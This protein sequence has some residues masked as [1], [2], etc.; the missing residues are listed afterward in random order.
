MKNHILSRRMSCVMILLG[1]L[2]PLSLVLPL[3]LEYAARA[4]SA[5]E[6][7]ALSPETV[8][9][10]HLSSTASALFQIT[11]H[12]HINEVMPK[13]EE[14]AFEWVE[15]RNPRVFQ[16]YL[17]LILRNASGNNGSMLLPRSPASLSAPLGGPV[18]ISGWQITDEDG[19]NYTI[20]DALP[21]V[22]R[23][24]Y[25]LILFDGLGPANDDYDLSDGVAV[26]HSPPGVA[27]I[28]EDVADQVA[29]Y[30][31]STHSPDTIQDFVAYGAPAGDQAANAVAADLWQESWQVNIYIGAG[32]VVESEET[33]AGQS[34]GL[35]PEQENHSP[36][37]WALY[38][39]DDVT[40]GAPNPMPQVYWSAVDDGAVMG[41]DGFALGWSWVPN[42]T[43]QLQVDDDPAFD[44]PW[45][46]QILDDPSYAPEGPVPAGNYWWQVR[47]IDRRGVAGAWSLPAQVSVVAVGASGGPQ[48]TGQAHA[49]MQQHILPI[50]WLRQRKDTR[51]LCLDGC[52][53]GDPGDDSPEEAWDSVHPNRIYEHGRQNCALASIAMIVTNYGGDLSQDRLGYRLFE[54][55][56]AP[57]QNEGGLGEPRVDLGHDRFASGCGFVGGATRDL[58]AWALGVDNSDIHYA[59]LKPSFDT[60]RSWLDQGRPILRATSGHATVIGGYRILDDGTEQVRLLN[61]WSGTTWE[62]YNSLG[63]LCHYAAPV[64]APNVRSDE[65]SIST[66]EDGDGIMDW[67]E[68]YRFPTDHTKGDT[69]ADGQ[70]DKVDISEYLFDLAGGYH[71]R[72]PDRDGDGL[73]KEVDPDNDNGGSKDGCED[74]NHNGRYEPALGETSNFKPT[75]EKQCV[76]PVGE[77]VYIPAGEFQMGCDETN[78]NEDCGDYELPLHTVYLD[79]YYIDRY[80][81]TNAQYAQCV[82]AGFCTLPLHSYSYARPSYYNNPVYAYYPVIYISWHDA[83]DYCTWLGKRLPT[84]AEWEKAARGSSDTRM[85]PWGDEALDCSRLN[86]RYWNGSNYV[87]C[88]GDTSQV[89]DYPTGASPYGVLD[90]SGNVWEWVNDWYRSDYYSY[91]PYSNPQG[92]PS[93]MYKVARGGCYR[94]DYWFRV[95]AR[96]WASPD[97]RTEDTSGFRCVSSP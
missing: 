69:D 7:I 54:N 57:F 62:N 36:A 31:S 18:D 2:L 93:G 9:A 90:M 35:H 53:Q 89:G 24:A 76:P 4:A 30:S 92:P 3:K 91:S 46:D 81:V 21:E 74:A 27:D 50:T 65:S 88:V 83:T 52:N 58:M 32:L 67:D 87:Y 84:E 56:G 41:S 38:R 77:M 78:P 96:A 55:F 60:V 19:N 59:L 49:V 15:L 42:A 66:D 14:G 5:A 8:T 71:P 80:E 68:Y 1:L 22:P 47:P 20:P 48:G 26:L 10:A 61:P 70:Q 37:D 75:Q 64:S 63:F 12:V 6:A 39:G 94:C 34:L 72:T 33:A 73:R 43:Y 51:L 40:P 95:A 25:V 45:L 29:L 44:S 85:Y 11:S 13:P 79:A 86:Y 16:V 17:P 28:L 23:D 97:N 82:A